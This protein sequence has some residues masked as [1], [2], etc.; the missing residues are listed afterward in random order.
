MH[1]RS[2]PRKH[3]RCFARALPLG[4]RPFV[5]SFDGSRF[6][7]ATQPRVLIK[8]LGLEHRL[9][10]GA[11]GEY[12]AARFVSK[13]ETFWV[14]VQR[15]PGGYA[16][17]LKN[18]YTRTWRWHT[19][20][21]PDNS[22]TSEAEHVERFRELFDQAIIATMRSSSDVVAHLSG[23]LD[24]SSVVCRGMELYRAGRLSQPLRAESVRYPGQPQDETKWS[25]QVEAHLG[26]E[27]T[28]ASEQPYN[29]DEAREWCRQTLHLPLRPNVLMASCD[30]LQSEGVRVL[31]TG[32]GGDDWL[33]RWLARALAGFG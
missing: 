32:E 22:A 20:P 24:S 16:L 21:F 14:G 4:W 12:L 17:L 1:L 15:L 18:G 3:A 26:I 23:G 27:A 30:R 7:F 33:G 2:G 10:E 29:F 28:V 5:W 11:I 6:G 13:D 19:G 9:N 31:L 25:S 8:G